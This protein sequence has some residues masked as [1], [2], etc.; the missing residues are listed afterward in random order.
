MHRLLTLRTGLRGNPGHFRPHHRRP[1]L[2]LEGHGWAEQLPRIRMRF[3]RRV[4][5]GLPDRDSRGE[6]GH[7]PGRAPSQRDHDLR[8]LRSRLLVQSRAARRRGSPYGSLQR[9][10]GER[11]SLV[12]EG[13][14]CLGLRDPQR[15]GA[16]ADDPGDDRRA[17]ARRQ[18]ARG[19][20]LRRGTIEIDPRSPRGGLYRWDHFVALHQRRGLRCPK[21]DQ[22]RL[23]QQQRRHLRPGVPLPHRFRP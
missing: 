4:R 7:Q 2:C 11:R 5:P 12:R 20:L 21:D 19:D 6:D 14:L 16:D 18:L 3:L 8:V 13:A 9:R 22:G 1:G 23:R 10:R 15:A 17:L